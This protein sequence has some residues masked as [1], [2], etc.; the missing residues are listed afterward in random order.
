MAV[1]FSGWNEDLL[2][3]GTMYHTPEELLEKNQ[4]WWFTKKVLVL[5]EKLT[6]GWG[7]DELLDK[8]HFMIQIFR[9]PL[10]EQPTLFNLLKIGIYTGLLLNTLKAQDFPEGIV[11]AF[12]DA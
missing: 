5:P 12:E 11:K 2:Y 7:V 3:N 9:I 10:Q 8:N 4:A 6:S 1:T